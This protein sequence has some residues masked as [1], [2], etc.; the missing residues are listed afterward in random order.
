MNINKKMAAVV[1]AAV[2]TTYAPLSAMGASIQLTDSLKIA[3]EKAAGSADTALKTRLNSSYSE[4]S[5][6]LAQQAALDRNIKNVHY[7][8]EEALIAVRKQVM[9]IDQ[10]KVAQLAVKVQQTKDKYK[11]L[12][13]L[14]SSVSGTKK[15]TE[16][17][18]AVQ[19]AREDIRLKERQLKAAKEDKAKKIKDIRSTL[20]AIDAV[21]LQIKSAKGVVDIPT[22][23]CSAEWADFKQ[24]VKK[25][26]VKRT[27]ESLAGVVSLT[28]QIIEQKKGVHTLETKISG[29][30]AKAKQQIP[31]K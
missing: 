19:L 22:K 7:A 2:L 31:V 24:L 6:L 28:R 9:L 20:S 5:S 30:I 3:V 1:L 15:A 12:F 8:S 27:A 16:L 4:L 14:Y 23:R 29:I 10:D 17:K 18:L 25:N 26:D 21:K 13:V 11:P